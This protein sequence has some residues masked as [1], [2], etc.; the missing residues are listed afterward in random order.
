MLKRC[1]QNLVINVF[2]S[3]L[4]CLHLYYTTTF[5]EIQTKIEKTYQKKRYLLEI[6]VFLYDIIWRYTQKGYNNK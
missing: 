1:F 4:F 5:K 6:K 2:I 3:L